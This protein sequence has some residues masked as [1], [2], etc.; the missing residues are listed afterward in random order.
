MKREQTCLVGDT[1]RRKCRNESYE[2]ET[3][4]RD[5]E[6]ETGETREGGDERKRARG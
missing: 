4:S 5:E 2:E 1:M 3:R 6:R